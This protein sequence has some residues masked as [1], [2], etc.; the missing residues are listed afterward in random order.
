MVMCTMLLS[1]FLGFGKRQHELVMLKD[2]AGRHRRVLDAYTEGFLEHVP[3]LLTPAAIVCYM[4]YTVAAE[5]VAK[6]G[7]RNL[8]Y[9]TPLVIYGLMRYLF[10]V[11][12]DK[13]VGDPTQVI[14]SDRPLVINILLWIVVCGLMIYI[15]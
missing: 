12:E 10:L 15:K 11:Y 3:Y 5:T 6:F 14:F 2:N 8:I 7:T 9:T 1:L 4:L 13:N